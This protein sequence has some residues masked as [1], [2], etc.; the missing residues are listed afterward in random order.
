MK[1]IML[2]AVLG[3]FSTMAHAFDCTQEVGAYYNSSGTKVFKITLKEDN[4]RRA[5]YEI[6]GNQQG[7]DMMD[8]A[9]VEPETCDILRTY[10]I[11]SE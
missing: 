5:V 10:N 7:G 8:E 4:G 3:L 6:R 11:W 1:K 2:I 9:I